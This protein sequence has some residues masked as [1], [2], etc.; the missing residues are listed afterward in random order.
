[1]PRHSIG[2]A[3]IDVSDGSSYYWFY[4]RQG[5][6]IE[7]EPERKWYCLWL[8]T[9]ASDDADEIECSVTLRGGAVRDHHTSESCSNCD[10]LDV[11][12]PAYWGASVPQAYGAADYNLSVEIDGEYGQFSGTVLF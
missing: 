12:G 1:M 10:G 5:I 9:A 7:I 4:R 2:G 6:S 8:C 11:M 3:T